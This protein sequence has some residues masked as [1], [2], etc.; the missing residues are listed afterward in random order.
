MKAIYHE[1]YGSADVLELQDLDTPAI[2]DDEV[3]I[4]VHAA[5]V[6]PGDCLALRGAPY[7]ARLM[8]YGLLGP[9]HN[10]PGTD[11]AGRVAAIG[12]DVTRF[13]PEDDVFGWCVGAFA[14]YASTSERALQR[15]PAHLTFEQAA[16]IPTAATAALQGLRDVGRIQTGHH[17]L[18]IGASGGVGTFAV[19]IAKAF[20]AEVTGVCSTRNTDL[21]RSA[22][23]DQVIDYSREDFT[24]LGSRYDVIID[25]VGKESLS[26]A[27]RVLK[28]NG[29]FVVVGGQSGRSVTG[30]E[31]FVKALALS[32]FIR[33]RLRPLF[34]TKS[35]DD[36]AVLRELLD[37]GKVLPVIDGVYDLRDVPGAIRYVEAGHSRGKVVISV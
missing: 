32:P 16:A 28:P 37:N 4:R 14:E 36:L 29:T 15:K 6:N 23:A 17:V 22:G 9:K 12:K 34:S 11:V 30:M 8:G 10:V 27:S 13:Q 21:V 3:L 1:T 33:R 25:T 24:R 2:G 35:H 18:V 31:R 19:Q 7:V 5:S 20:G 26:S